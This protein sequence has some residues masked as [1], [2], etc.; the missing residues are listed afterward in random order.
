MS[1]KIVNI[2][3]H[4]LAEEYHLQAGFQI[5]SINAQPIH[6]VI[7][8]MY[9]AQNK[10][11]I[12]EYLDLQ[13]LPQTCLITNN[14]SKPLGLEV[15]LLPCVTCVNHCLFC[16]VDQMPPGCR[17]SLYVKDD[18]LIY[19]FFYG[20]F[21]TLTNLSPADWNKI[22][23]QHISPLY[24]SVHTT[25]PYLHQKMLRYTH[26]FNIQEALKKLQAEKI[27]L[28]TQIVVVPEYND[29]DVLNQTIID[30]AAMENVASICIVPVGLT[31]H[32]NNLPPLR[33]LTTTEAFTIIDQTAILK[34]TLRLKHVYCADELFLTAHLPLPP[35]SYYQDFPQLENGV[36]MVTLAREHWSKKKKQFLNLF[37]K[38]KSDLVFITSVSGNLALEPMIADFSP[39]LG[40]QKIR[41]FPVLNHFLG[42]EVTVTGLLAW[43]DIKQQLIL[44]KNERPVFSSVMFN[45][46]HQT[47]DGVKLAEIEK[48][49]SQKVIV[50]DEL[51]NHT[52]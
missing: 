23:K 2:H 8:L 10:Q 48:E 21:I 26:H 47:I 36:G 1:V 32:R 16:F 6:D 29:H 9:Y 25:N 51:F 4:S 12:I 22:I 52:K 20:N 18:D 15:E 7:D 13:R 11:L 44:Q 39:L 50:L 49:L 14:F 34:K 46:D 19:S 35:K 30:L 42:E 45:D 43:Q 31:K 33:K 5:E 41:L 38:L 27:I 3:P 17:N 24:V 37:Q 40:T 28:H